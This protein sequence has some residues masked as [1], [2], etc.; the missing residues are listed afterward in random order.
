MESG[1]VS[2]SLFVTNRA[3]SFDSWPISL[4]S[5][6]SRLPFSPSRVSFRMSPT[7]GGIRRRRFPARF[8]F[9]RKES[10]VPKSSGSQDSRLLPRFRL[11]TFTFSKAARR[12]SETYRRPKP[13]RSRLSPPSWSLMMARASSMA[14][15]ELRRLS[16]RRKKATPAATARAAT[17][18]GGSAVR[19]WLTS[20][21]IFAAHAARTVRST[22][23][24]LSTRSSNGSL[25]GVAALVSSVRAEA[26]KRSP[27]LRRIQTIRFTLVKNVSLIMMMGD[28]GPGTPASTVLREKALPRSRSH[29]AARS[30]RALASS[31][32]D[33]RAW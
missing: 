7:D 5:S 1:S 29:F 33:S 15:A 32:G 6:R 4:G 16:L 19:S 17:T 30:L 22:S 20:A 11:S 26:E 3:R 18:A 27:R 31:L 25:T 24:A 28:E 23:I 21:S 13:D 9:I 2:S 10:R 12:S 8:S 14:L